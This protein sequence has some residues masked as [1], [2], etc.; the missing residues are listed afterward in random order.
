MACTQPGLRP[1][2]RWHLP[3]GEFVGWHLTLVNVSGICG[4]SPHIPLE[5]KDIL[6]STLCSPTSLS[7]SSS[8][9]QTPKPRAPSSLLRLLSFYSVSKCGLL[10]LE[11]TQRRELG[12]TQAR[13]VESPALK[14]LRK[15]PHNSEVAV[16][17]ALEPPQE[18]P[19]TPKNT[20]E[21]SFQ[22]LKELP[23]IEHNDTCKAYES[24]NSYY[25]TQTQVEED[26]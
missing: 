4:H 12:M 14:N 17:K 5:Y 2:H 22:T 20:P 15:Q 9:R 25:S 18:H 26:T 16:W 21:Q 6:Q 8:S 11:E 19:Q 1:P 24:K 23:L 13:T 7:S 3:L 10:L